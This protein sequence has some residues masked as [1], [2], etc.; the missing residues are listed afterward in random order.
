MSGSNCLHHT[1]TP[2]YPVLLT[3]AAVTMARAPAQICLSWRS[4]TIQGSCYDTGRETQ[5]PLVR[6]VQTG[7]DRSPSLILLA[8]TKKVRLLA[9]AS[10]AVRAKPMQ[11]YH[12]QEQP[13]VILLIRRVV[14]GEGISPVNLPCTLRKRPSVCPCSAQARTPFLPS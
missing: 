2:P 11:P 4:A 10:A 14:V 5:P 3:L 9:M 1:M 7:S 8:Q 6:W 13:P 12:H